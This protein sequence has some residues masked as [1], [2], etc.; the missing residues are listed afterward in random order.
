MPRQVYGLVLGALTLALAGCGGPVLGKVTGR[1]SVGGKPVTS[2]RV[3]FYPNGR[4]ATG[5]IAADG[6]Y[7]LTTYASGDGALVGPHKVAIHA[8]DVGPGSLRQPKSIEEEM[9]FS[10]LGTK[11]ILVPGKVTW[12]VPEKYSVA[13]TSGL[14]A[15]VQAGDN[16]IDFEI[17]AGR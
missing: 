3:M 4:G 15:T 17:P 7:T 10:K 2:G 13:E 9:E 11:Q 6:T 14:T 8:T 1:I 12:L 5:E 16:K